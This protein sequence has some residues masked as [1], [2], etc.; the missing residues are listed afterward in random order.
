MLSHFCP[1][2][3]KGVYPKVF[4]EDGTLNFLIVGCCFAIYRGCL[5]EELFVLLI[6]FCMGSFEGIYRL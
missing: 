2:C 1:I 5:A 6:F 4:Q 3:N